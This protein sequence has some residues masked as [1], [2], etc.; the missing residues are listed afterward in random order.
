MCCKSIYSP[1]VGVKAQG[2]GPCSHRPLLFLI[3]PAFTQ[4]QA[5]VSRLGALARQVNASLRDVGDFE[6]YVSVV[7]ELAQGAAEGLER[8]ARQQQRQLPGQ[9]GQGTEGGSSSP[10]AEP[11]EQKEEPAGL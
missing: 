3:A 9:G 8:Q 2:P 4:A 10:A 6:N 1:A 7:E 11:P 5:N